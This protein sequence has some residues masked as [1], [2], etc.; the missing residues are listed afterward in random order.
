[1]FAQLFF[2]LLAG[3]GV[4]NRRER[5]GNLV[6]HLD[7]QAEFVFIE[8]IRLRRIRACLKNHE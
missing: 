7:Q 5:K 8:E 1:M 3:V 2:C 4:G 6:V